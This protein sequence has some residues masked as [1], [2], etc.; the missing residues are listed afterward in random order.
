ML[1]DLVNLVDPRGENPLLLGVIVFI[2]LSEWL[3][4]PS[5]AEPPRDDVPP[6]SL[7]LPG[8]ALGK[9]KPFKC[10]STNNGLGNP[11]K[12]KTAQEIE[13][14]FLKKGFEKR[15]PDPINGYGGYVN[16]RTGRSYHIDPKNFGK[17]KEPNHID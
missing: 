11:F 15:G 14:M 6:T 10:V 16:P 13:N 1:G 4:A 9:L 2:G 17:Y 7:L 3:N 5:V 12:N 8:S